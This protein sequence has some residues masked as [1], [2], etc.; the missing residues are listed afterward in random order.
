MV[1]REERMLEVLRNMR[2]SI[3]AAVAVQLLAGGKPTALRKAPRTEEH[4]AHR[5]RRQRERV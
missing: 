2:R 1:V 3:D 4:W 5:S